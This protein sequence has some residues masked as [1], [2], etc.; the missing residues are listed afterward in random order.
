MML[1]KF[2][3]LQSRYH[4]HRDSFDLVFIFILTVLC[5]GAL[6]PFLGFYW[7]DLPYL[8][9]LSAFGPLGFPRYVA[10]DRPFS[11]WIFMLTTSVFRYH[12]YAY[13][14]LAL[15]LRFLASVL[16]FL[17]LKILWPEKE[18][19]RFFSAILLTVYPGFLQQPIALIYNHHLSVLCL[20]LLSLYLMLK[21]VETGKLKLPLYIPSVLLT[22]QVFSIE[23]FA[24]LELIRPFLLWVVLKER[25][26]N[27]KDRARKG[28]LIWAPY[29]IIFFGFIFWRAFIFK[30][31]TYEPALL[32][33][34]A[35]DPITAL[36]Q[37]AQR[38]PADIATAFIGAWSRTVT[39]PTISGFGRGATYLF[40]ALVMG[41]LAFSLLTLCLRSKPAPSGRKTRWS[42]F[43]IGAALFIQGIALIWILNFPLRIE[44]PWDRMTIGLLPGIALL[45]GN[46]LSLLNQKSKVSATVILSALIALAV[47][48]HF[49]NGMKYKRDWENLQNLFQQIAWRMPALEPHSALLSSEPGVAFYSDN[50]LTS[51]L[52]LTYA[53]KIASVELEYFFF[54]SDVRI[55]LAFPEL[56][57]DNPI[58]QGYRSF[59][60]SGNTSRMI[61]LQYNPPACLQ[62]MDRI[63]S[64]SITNLNLTDLQTRELR[65]TDLDLIRPE[66]QHRPPAFLA[67]EPQESSWCYYFQKADLARQYGD[68][69]K[70]AKLGDQAL[71]LGLAPR[72]ASEWLP[73]LEG[74]CWLGRWGEAETV[75]SAISILQPDYNTGVC[76]TLRRIKNT[77]GFPH[78][79]EMSDL[80]K[81]YN[82]Q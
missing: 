16:F 40:W 58:I 51:P 32:Q 8:Y 46:G 23:N 81:V 61:A 11:A 4:R 28:L 19:L 37:L 27:K 15:A 73:F 12:A 50:S 44:F 34:L 67:A 41:S 79:Q 59:T 7:D 25:M 31:P 53:G 3:K 64:N 9:Q 20:F 33:T 17:N 43:I 78:P 75:L 54:Y 24:L 82:C 66:P 57:K 38:I 36:S 80:L 6:I 18:N 47:G 1:K 39:I 14:L 68:Y 65:L 42:I 62:V 48:S 49:E 13:H 77:A 30:F 60:F 26:E 10:T 74:Y 76:Y 72:V 45:A 29:L 56:T 55:G 52:N 69:Q 5:Y 70:I 21:S 2:P 63:Y 22:L 35:N 71:S